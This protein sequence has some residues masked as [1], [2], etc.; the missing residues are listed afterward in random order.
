MTPCQPVLDYSNEERVI[1]TVHPISPNLLG[2]K[3]WVQEFR[4]PRI[5]D[6]DWIWGG[7]SFTAKQERYRGGWAWL[8]RWLWWR[9]NHSPRFFC[10]IEKSE[11]VFCYGRYPAFENVIKVIFSELRTGDGGGTFI[12]LLWLSDQHL[13]PPYNI[14]VFFGQ[15]RT[16]IVS[17]RTQNKDF[18][19]GWDQVWHF[20]PDVIPSLPSQS[21]TLF[22]KWKRGV[23]GCSVNYR[24]FRVLKSWN[25]EL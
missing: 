5:F 10:V 8:C 22:W 3:N 6:R 20:Y 1:P 4:W 2:L 24:T 23:T 18:G 17:T 11:T 9:G 25:N 15:N 19:M 7:V 13:S 12:W 16:D 14:L 21:L